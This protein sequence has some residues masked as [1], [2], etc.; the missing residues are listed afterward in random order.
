MVAEKFWS[1]NRQKAFYDVKE[2]NTFSKSYANTPLVPCH[3]RLE[4]DKKGSYKHRV[5]EVEHGC[6]SPLVLS[7]SGGLV[8]TAMVV[9]KRIASIIAEKKEQ[10]YSLT[11]FWLR[12]RLSFSLLRSA[13]VCLR[14]SR[15]S[16]H[17]PSTANLFES[18][19]DL[20]SSS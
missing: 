7:T 19:I 16:Y 2:Y 17:R 11:L 20:M 12:C 4:Q 13:I 8:P 18:P 3:R 15:S 14:G 10:P 6:I 5:K 1:R 9:Y